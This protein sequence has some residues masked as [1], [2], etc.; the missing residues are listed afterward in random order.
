ML[1]LEF[2]KTRSSVI[3]KKIGIFAFSSILFALP[4]IYF[5]VFV[6]HLK[7]LNYAP[8]TWLG[9]FNISNL[10]ADNV[11]IAL[12]IAAIG[13]VTLP[14]NKISKR[15]LRLW[16]CGA[17]VF[18]IYSLAVTYFSRKQIAYLPAFVPWFHF[19]FY[20]K[21][22]ETVLFGYGL[23]KLCELLFVEP[24]VVVSAVTVMLFP[25]YMT[26]P[27]F[28][29]DRK[30]ALLHA[31]RFREIAAYHWIREHTEPRDVFLSSDYHSLFVI[32][33]AGRKTVCT[34]KEFSN[35]F[36][37][38]RKRDADRN[39]M[40]NYLRKNHHTEFQ[41]LAENYSLDY[42]ISTDQT[43]VLSLLQNRNF[44]KSFESLGLYIFERKTSDIN[45]MLL[46]N[47]DM[48]L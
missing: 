15:I 34:K 16:I 13:L 24:V 23:V 14:Q 22:A 29:E 46:G 10:I 28:M 37:N 26:R 42:V 3:L 30:S 9:S 35:P 38:F 7:T 19:Y 4:L 47:S 12:L 17:A 43:F 48:I 36:V 45:G 11:N 25:A 40:F 31:Q 2:R 8:N 32:N 39:Q 33:P 20:L 21:A 6:H 44:S 1:A 27:D 41:E 18:L 5:L